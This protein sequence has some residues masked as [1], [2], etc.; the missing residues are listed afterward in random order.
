MLLSPTD[1]TDECFLVA[2]ELFDELWD[3][4]PIRLIGVTAN[5]VEDAGNRQLNL[6]D[7]ESHDKKHKLD[8]ALDSIREKYGKDAIR[9]GSLFDRTSG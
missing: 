5:K 7:M 3:G 6:F 2:C 8:T 1:V 4:S 9:R